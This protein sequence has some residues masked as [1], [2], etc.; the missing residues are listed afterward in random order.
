MMKYRKHIFICTNQK[1]PGK[2]SCGE[3]HGMALVAAFKNRIKEE[4]WKDIRAQRAG[5]LDLCAFG[6]AAMVYPE[7][8]C[9]GSL[10]LEDVDKII[11]QDIING[12]VYLEKKLD[13]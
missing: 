4:G 3:A 6:P 10:E 2:K 12:G 5:C 13:F 8:T 7:G 9:Y 11:D 1:D